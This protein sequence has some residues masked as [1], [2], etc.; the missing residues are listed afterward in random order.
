M[1]VAWRVEGPS[2][3]EAVSGKETVVRSYPYSADPSTLDWNRSAAV[4]LI[5]ELAARRIL[6]NLEDE[7]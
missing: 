6:E 3:R 4:R 2:T 5:A 7:P 1:G